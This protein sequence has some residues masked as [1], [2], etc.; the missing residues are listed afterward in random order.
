MKNLPFSL[1]TIFILLFGTS[2]AYAGLIEADY[3]TDGDNL[4]VYDEESSLTW[5]DFS[6]FDVTMGYEDASSS[7]DGY[8]MATNDEVIELFSNF[9]GDDGNVSEITNYNEALVTAFI[10]LFGASNEGEHFLES[11]GFYLDETN[12]LRKAGAIEEYPIDFDFGSSESTYYLYGTENT[13]NY[14]SYY[15]SGLVYI[16]YFMVKETATDVPE[17]TGLALFLFAAL[18][19]LLT[20][21]S[22]M[23]KSVPKLTS[24]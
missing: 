9:F 22:Q 23:L 7:Y 15:D 3:A 21:R 5:L 16:S 1:L 13:S 8:R 4:A 19:L 18:G 24:E 20:Q 2:K 14:D 17:P 6:V 11:V 10:D 12:M